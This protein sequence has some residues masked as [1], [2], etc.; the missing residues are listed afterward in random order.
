MT[1]SSSRQVRYIL[2]REVLRLF[3]ANKDL[4]TQLDPES[5]CHDDPNS[6][7]RLSGGTEILGFS[8]DQPERMA[9]LSGQYLLFI[10]D[11]ASGVPESIFEALEGNRAG[12]ARILMLSNPTRTSGTFYEAFADPIKRALWKSFTVS[13]EDTPTARGLAKIPGLATSDWVKEK[14]IEWGPEYLKSPLYLVRVKGEFPRSGDKNVVALS[15]VE[16]ALERYN[17]TEAIGPITAGLDPSG[18]GHD[19][20]VLAIVQGLKALPSR[21]WKK[22]DGHM[23]AHQVI[24]ALE[25]VRRGQPV[26]LNVDSIGIGA[27]VYGVL[28][29]IKPDWLRVIG[30]K[31]STVSNRPDQY[32]LL[33]DELW[34][35]M[36]QWLKV[37][38]I[39]KDSKL[40]A[41]LVAPEFDLDHKGRIKVESKKEL[42]KKIGRS[43]DRADALALALC[44][45]GVTLVDYQKNVERFKNLFAKD[46]QRG[47][48]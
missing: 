19:E 47:T 24:T 28:K 1:S 22:L 13:S 4:L 42:K 31:A 6:G 27:D 11:E 14:R 23:L 9:G 15:T 17:K 29:R 33:R 8:T 12:G 7:L 39:P 21:T 43:P 16:D 48:P 46:K 41:E 10:V 20:S 30:V 18:E 32:C 40:E 35:E 45:S 36:G 26:T 44:R 25:E 38:A 2:W 5:V 3:R 37:G 34:F